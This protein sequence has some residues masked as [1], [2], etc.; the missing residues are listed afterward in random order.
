VLDQAEWL[1]PEAEALEV[2]GRDGGGCVDGD[3][4]AGEGYPDRGGAFTLFEEPARVGAELRLDRRPA[5]G[6]ENRGE[7]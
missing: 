6:R 2:A 3:P 5:R 7:Q 4:G 1:Q